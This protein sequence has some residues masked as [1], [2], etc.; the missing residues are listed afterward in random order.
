MA[1]REAT[2][3]D[4]DGLHIR[5]AA[6]FATAARRTGVSVTVA[7]VPD[8]APVAADSVL[9]VLAL[10]VRQGDRVR[11]AADGEGAD[12]ALDALV[13][14]LETASDEPDATADAAP[15]ADAPGAA[16]AARDGEL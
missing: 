4:V 16:S 9:A 15:P 10:D 7:K 12:A 2:V 5:P 14:L 8:G 3:A 6:V 1:Q 11:L 13:T